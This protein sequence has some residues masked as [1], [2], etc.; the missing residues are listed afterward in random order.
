MIFKSYP[1][2][3][4]LNIIRQYLTVLDLEETKVFVPDECFC[5]EKNEIKN[6]SVPQLEYY[7]Y[8]IIQQMLADKQGAELEIFL[9]ELLN[10]ELEERKY[11]AQRTDTYGVIAEISI[12]IMSPEL[13]HVYAV[14]TGKEFW[15]VWDSFVIRGYREIITFKDEQTKEVERLTD[16]FYEAILR[17]DEDEFV[18]FW[19]DTDMNF[20]DRMRRCF[21]EWKDRFRMI[22]DSGEESVE[23]ILADIAENM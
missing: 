19:E 7:A 17:Q 18:E 6:A 1:G 20:S 3:I 14:A 12:Y 11:M 16:P 9:K 22:C 10:A 15:D 2:N 4:N 21:D 23:T 5:G 13:V 8:E